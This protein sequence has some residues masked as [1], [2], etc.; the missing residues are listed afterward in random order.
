MAL[1]RIGQYPTESLKVMPTKLFDHLKC[2]HACEANEDELS[3]LHKRHGNIL[4]S[5]TVLKTDHV[6]ELDNYGHGHQ[7]SKSLLSSSNLNNYAQVV[8]PDMRKV[9]NKKIYTIGKLFTLI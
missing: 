2:N 5:W 3:V 7:N 4:T 6:E 8:V 9:Q 1:K